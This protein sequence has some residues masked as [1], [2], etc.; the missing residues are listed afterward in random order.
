MIVIGECIHVISSKV[1]AAIEARD[2]K[3]IQELARLQV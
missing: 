3:Y 2:K 1:K